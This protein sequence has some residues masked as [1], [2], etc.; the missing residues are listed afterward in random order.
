MF[1]SI[2]DLFLIEFL[3]HN[4][5]FEGWK[6]MSSGKVITKKKY[7]SVWQLRAGK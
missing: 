5:L 2:W 1:N 7:F 6:I 3:H 4:E